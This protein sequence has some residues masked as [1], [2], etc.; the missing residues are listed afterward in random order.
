MK[1][2]YIVELT[3]A[4]FEAMFT[5]LV[6]GYTEKFEVSWDEGEIDKREMKMC[7]KAFTQLNI[8]KNKG[9]KTIK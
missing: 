7:D 8:A 6:H 4:E 9:L 1:K 3:K 2:R 5:V